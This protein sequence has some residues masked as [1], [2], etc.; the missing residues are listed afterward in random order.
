VF[1]AKIELQ[2]SVLFGFSDPNSPDLSFKWINATACDLKYL[3]IDGDRTR[4]VQGKINN[5]RLR[6]WK[7]L[8]E[9]TESIV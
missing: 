7:E 3:S 2:R 6:F 9:S 5:N 8:S 4:M 1:I